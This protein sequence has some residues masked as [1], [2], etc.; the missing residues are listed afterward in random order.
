[1]KGHEKVLEIGGNIGR[2]TLVIASILNSSNL[3]TLECN[4]ESCNQLNENKNLNKFSFFIE[5]SALSAK[6]LIQIG[7]NVGYANEIPDFTSKILLEDEYEAI[8]VEPNPKSLNRCKE[9]YKKFQIDK[10]DIIKI[11]ARNYKDTVL[12][13]PK[14]SKDRLHPTPQAYR[15]LAKQTRIE[16]E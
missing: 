16:K 2:N 13:I 15:E 7:A 12:T 3:V 5:N 10:Q 4:L 9:G 6:K 11:V 14:L 1:M 8:L